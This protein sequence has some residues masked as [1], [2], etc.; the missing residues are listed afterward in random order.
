MA[1]SDCIVIMGANMAENHPVGF[2]FVM[3][4]KERGATLIHV[5]PRFSRTSAMADLHVPLRAG[6]D[7]VFLGAL[8]NHVV[9]SARWNADPFFKEYVTHYTNAPVIVDREFRDTE[10][11]GGLFSGYVPA[12][13][14]YDTDTW[15]YAG[16]QLDPS[17]SQHRDQ[18]VQTREGGAT[19]G[20]APASQLDSTL[21]DPHCVFQLVRRHFAR[22]TPEMV[23]QVTGCPPETFTKVAETILENSGR[24]RTTAFAYAV[25]WTQ[26]TNGPQM[27]GCCALLQLLLGNMG[28][29]GGGIMALRGHA[30]IQGSTDVPTLYHSIH[31]YMPAFS[32]LK[33]H[34]TIR[35][36]IATEANPTSYWAN[37]PK[38]LVSYLKSM[39]GDAA[40]AEN[41]FGYDWHPKITG[42]H[43]HMPMFVAMADGKV[44]GMLCVGQNP[45]T[46]LNAK[47]E[48]KGLRQLE[49]LVVR[50][51]FLTE[52]ATFWN[53][54]PENE[55]GEVKPEDIATGV[56]F[57]PAAQAAESDGSFTNT[58]RMLQWHFKAAEAPGQCRT[59]LWFTHQL[60]L[61]LKKM[62]AQ[63]ELPRDQ[64]IRNLLW[65]FDLDEA[66]QRGS[67]AAGPPG[68]PDPHKVL[69]EINGYVTGQ[70]DQHLDG[71]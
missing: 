56:F 53:R 68:E 14:R 61:R 67:G 52:T 18:D 37:Y 1:D 46:S 15:Q 50:D 25:A 60:A 24:D 5:D 26:H 44:K 8:V 34:A 21:Q 17:A 6:S 35:D 43:S 22:Y 4:A 55:A 19:T 65:E 48:R 30:S 38:F 31:G 2:R 29:P 7:L 3:K 41:D 23:E 32:A 28:R 63:S 47:L 70:P 45:A 57:M 11:L 49:W 71:F 33:D 20:A 62:Y 39:Y 12:E 36:Y 54:S 9:N 51:I 13:R 42:D 59:D 16:Q 10:D 40:T 66:G 69:R 58:Q 64:G 27:I